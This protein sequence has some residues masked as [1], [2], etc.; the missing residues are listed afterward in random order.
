MW[1]AQTASAFND[2]RNDQFYELIAK[3]I[4]KIDEF[5]AK[6]IKIEVC[7][8]NMIFYYTI[9]KVVKNVFPLKFLSRIVNEFLKCR[10]HNKF[11][12]SFNFTGFY[13]CGLNY[14]SVIHYGGFFSNYSNRNQR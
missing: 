10:S 2:F 6:K 7:V 14:A 5:Y 11:V 12:H 9:K 4:L 1:W 3:K 8:V 13:V